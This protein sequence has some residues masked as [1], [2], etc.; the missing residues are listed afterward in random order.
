MPHWTVDQLREHMAEALARLRG[1]RPLVHHIANAVTTQEVANAT[2][3]L[4]ASP[5]MADAPEEVPQVTPRARALSLNLGTLSAPRAKAIHLAAQTAR[6]HGI[7]IV[8][9]PTGV[10]MTSLRASLSLELLHEGITVTRGNV[11]E[12][13][14]V[15]GI[16]A[17]ARG[18]DAVGATA[19]PQDVAR[20]CATR[21]GVVAAV[22]GAVDVINDGTCSVRIA[23]GHP[24]LASVTGAGCI[25][26]ALIAAFCATGASP[27]IASAA[28][29]C[30]LDIAAERAAAQAA[31][32]GSFR[33]ALFDHLALLTPQDLRDVDGIAIRGQEDGV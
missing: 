5:V 22:T 1:E 9:D 2:L 29:L 30:A 4:G 14:Y 15:A 20:R 31:G 7:P 24:L 13:A 11:A 8:L 28:G 10:A 23:R 12:I 26:T 32:P 19:P 25:A 33:V 18:V 17:I 21:Y 3:A 27:L 6:A 16:Q